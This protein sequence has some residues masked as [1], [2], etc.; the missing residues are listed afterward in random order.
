MPCA[1]ASAVLVCDSVR[2]AELL[3]AAVSETGAEADADARA[4][5]V[6]QAVEAPQGVALA[7]AVR[8]TLRDALSEAQ[9]EPL[10]ETRA[11]VEM[12]G[13]ALILPEALGLSVPAPRAP[14]LLRLGLGDALGEALI[15]GDAEGLLLSM[16][17]LRLGRDVAL[18]QVLASREG[19]CV[20]MELVVKEGK[21]EV[22]GAAE[23]VAPEAVG[24]PVPVALPDAAPEAVTAPLAEAAGLS[25][26]C[27]K[28][29]GVAGKAVPVPAGALLGEAMDS[30]A[31]A[32]GVPKA[33]GVGAATLPLG[34]LAGEGV[35]VLPA[36][37]P[38]GVPVRHRLPVPLPLCEAL[39]GAL[40]LAQG[41]GQGTALAE[42]LWLPAPPPL[43]ALAW[44]PVAERSRESE[45]PRL[46]LALPPV[47]PALALALGLSASAVGVGRAG[48]ALVE[49]LASAL[50][51]AV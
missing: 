37:L 38:L 10:L 39:G 22:L 3:P 31:A 26:P 21:G 9:A 43:V 32:L 20:P 25:V 12:L 51:A 27:S 13:D 4:L 7:L 34:V 42:V 30:V 28:T 16:R 47:G 18:L 48:V 17:P 24:R 45:G 46:T 49:A 8:V 11:E 6:L 15:E 44:L 35:A 50:E 2:P 5:A 14:P 23:P 33:E 40:P 1:D 41:L 29:V 36:P 19:L